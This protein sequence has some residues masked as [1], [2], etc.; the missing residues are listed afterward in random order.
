MCHYALI[1]YFGVQNVLYFDLCKKTNEAIT[2]DAEPLVIAP[3]ANLGGFFNCT[4]K[5]IATK[6]LANRTSSL[7]VKEN[8]HLYCTRGTIENY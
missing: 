3:C 4:L 5:T 8:G 1:G 6:G 2:R 7:K